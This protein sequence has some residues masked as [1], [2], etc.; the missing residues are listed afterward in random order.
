M[1][2]KSILLLLVVGTLFSF[3]SCKQHID[4]NVYVKTTEEFN[5]LVKDVEF[6]VGPVPE[7]TAYFNSKT[8]IVTFKTNAPNSVGDDFSYF[9]RN[10]KLTLRDINPDGDYK[11]LNNASTRVTIF[12]CGYD[13]KGNLSTWNLGLIDVVL[14][15]YQRT[16]SEA[17]RAFENNFALGW[18]ATNGEKTAVLSINAKDNEMIFTVPGGTKPSYAYYSV[19]EVKEGNRVLKIGNVDYTSDFYFA[20]GEMT[21]TPSK[22]NEQVNIDIK[23]D[24][25]TEKIIKLTKQNVAN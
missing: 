11:A 3:I 9:F 8:N 5:T 15:L 1:K 19:K 6:R 25:N 20:P 4:T 22:P 24:K 2:R 17:E 12:G 18:T 7:G 13:F 21:F 16:F 10:G 23:V 14:N